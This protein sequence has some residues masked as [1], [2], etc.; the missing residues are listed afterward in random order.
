VPESKNYVAL[1]KNSQEG[2]AKQKHK[3]IQFKKK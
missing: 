1:S 2:A 3:K